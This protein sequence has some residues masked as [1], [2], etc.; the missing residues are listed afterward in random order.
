MNTVSTLQNVQRG[1]LYVQG[2]ARKRLII[3][4]KM[5][6]Q[7]LKIFRIKCLKLFQ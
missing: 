5:L 6:F 1:I 3:K 2:I 7:K 4:M